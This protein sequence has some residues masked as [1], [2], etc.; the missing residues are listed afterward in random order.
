MMKVLVCGGRLYANKEKV[1]A[2]LNA[3]HK[4]HGIELIIHGAAKGADT[5]A[6]EWAKR[7]KIPVQA[8][9]ADWAQY[10]KPAGFIRNQKMLD[11]GEPD[12]VL[13]FPGGAGTEMM[14]AL[15]ERYGVK[16]IAY[17]GEGEEWLST[18]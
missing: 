6:A 15:A 8:Y 5:L 17:V 12:L 10:G 1:D 7:Y 2:A 14:C 18:I 3:I 9:S 4:K 16:V 13:A 11:L